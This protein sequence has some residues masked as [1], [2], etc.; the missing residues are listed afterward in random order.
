MDRVLWAGA[1]TFPCRHP[2][3]EP[4]RLLLPTL[5][6]MTHIAR[7]LDPHCTSFHLAGIGKAWL[8]QTSAAINGNNFSK[9]Q[10]FL[11][12]CRKPNEARI[13]FNVLGISKLSF[14]LTTKSR[15]CQIVLGSSMRRVQRSALFVEHFG[16][17]HAYND[18]QGGNLPLRTKSPL[19]N[20]EISFI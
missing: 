12:L 10:P 19:L 14:R 1:R 20:L 4:D 16:L 2:V 18:V 5:T 15:C 9:P 3:T 11:F 6:P 8:L 7:Q 13:S 17:V